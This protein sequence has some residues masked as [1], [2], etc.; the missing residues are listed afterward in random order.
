MTKQHFVLSQADMHANLSNTC[1]DTFVRRTLLF[2]C[3]LF[4][5]AFLFQWIH[6]IDFKS[7][8][9]CPIQQNTAFSVKTVFD[10]L[11]RKNTDTGLVWNVC[12]KPRL[13]ELVNVHWLTADRQCSSASP[14]LIRGGQLKQLCCLFASPSDRAP[15]KPRQREIRRAISSG[16]IIAR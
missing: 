6:Q 4:Y 5:S 11:A 1:F 13:C 10:T 16:R 15:K 9:Y 2:L 14:S 7:N 8:V 3:F 12:L